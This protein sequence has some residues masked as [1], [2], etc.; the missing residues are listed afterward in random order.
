MELFSRGETLRALTMNQKYLEYL[1]GAD[2]RWLLFV[3]V[4][5]SVENDVGLRMSMCGND[6][7]AI[8]CDENDAC[9]KEGI[10][11]SLLHQI[12]VLSAKNA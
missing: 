12:L 10:G 7:G 5:K 2:R 3:R 4:L 8:P 9:K 11:V 1:G 6:Q